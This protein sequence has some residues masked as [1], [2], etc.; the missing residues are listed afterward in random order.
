[1]DAR[2]LVLVLAWGCFE[3]HEPA[4]VG[5]TD[6]VEDDPA[7]DPAEIP[8]WLIGEFAIVG[9]GRSCLARDELELYADSCGNGGWWFYDLDFGGGG[10]GRFERVTDD[11]WELWVDG[12]RAVSIHR[13][14]WW[15]YEREMLRLDATGIG[16]RDELWAIQSENAPGVAHDLPERFC[17]VSETWSIHSTSVAPETAW[18]EGAVRLTE[19]GDTGL[20]V[21]FS[22][23]VVQLFDGR[24][25]TCG[26]NCARTSSGSVVAWDGSVGTIRYRNTHGVCSA[27]DGDATFTYDGDTLTLAQDWV[28]IDLSDMD[29]DGSIDDRVIRR[30]TTVLREDA[31]P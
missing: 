23:D 5:I 12:E 27:L 11:H 1:M 4:L 17:A 28:V 29:R 24:L 18:G 31:C 15:W 22:P 26:R 2:A 20:V 16:M 8:D 19:A 13:E 9:M 14:G 21:R 7:C 3:S 25:P 10:E 6:I 30:T